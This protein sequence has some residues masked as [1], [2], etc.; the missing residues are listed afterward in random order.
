MKSPHKDTG[1]KG[2]CVCVCAQVWFLDLSSHPEAETKISF[3][4]SWQRKSYN[5]MPWC[6]STLDGFCFVL[7]QD[8]GQIYLFIGIGTDT[9]SLIIYFPSFEIMISRMIWYVLPQMYMWLLD[10]LDGLML[11]A[12]CSAVRGQIVKQLRNDLD[13]LRIQRLRQVRCCFILKWSMHTKLTPTY[14]FLISTLCE[15]SGPCQRGIL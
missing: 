7:M 1:T 2:L 9:I 15:W 10:D 12:G 14:S 3:S 4:E 6:W 13:D 11:M 8:K 5:R